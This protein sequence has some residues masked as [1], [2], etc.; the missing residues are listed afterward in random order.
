MAEEKKESMTAPEGESLTTLLQKNLE[1]SDEIL[2][3][4]KEIKVF[5][6]WQ[7][8]WGFIRLL[9]IVV[10]I[11]LG[12]IYLPPLIREAMDSYQSLFSL[13]RF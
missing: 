13:K 4:S 1:R 2:R 6:R 3:L 10:P 5:I 8:A 9:I 11:I 12:F 7:Q